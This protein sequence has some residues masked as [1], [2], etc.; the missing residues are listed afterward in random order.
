MSEPTLIACLTPPGKGAVATLAI[1]G[2][3]A[4]AATRELFQANK[5]LP[6]TPDANRTWLGRLGEEARDQVVLAVKQAEPAVWL[7]LHCHGGVEVIRLVAELYERRG[8]RVVPWQELERL[9]G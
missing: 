7:E 4:W 6:E 5:P 3:L 9:T 8:V 1:R 2:P